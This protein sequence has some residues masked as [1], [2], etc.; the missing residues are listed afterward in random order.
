M[1]SERRGI[2]PLKLKVPRVDSLI[3]LR[4][5]LTP[6]DERD[7]VA[8][9]GKIMNLLTMNVNAMALASLAQFY[10]PSL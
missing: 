3:A 1:G 5:K 10:D 4:S 9:Y 6:M 8:S 7:S 2:I